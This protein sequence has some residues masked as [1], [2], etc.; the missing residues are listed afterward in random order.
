VSSVYAVFMITFLAYRSTEQVYLVPRL[1]SCVL[2]VPGGFPQSL[3]PDSG[4][5]HEL[6]AGRL[7]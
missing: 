2:K 6:L 5:Q 4:I 1:L 7:C 3:H